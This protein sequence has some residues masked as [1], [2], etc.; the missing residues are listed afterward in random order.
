MTLIHAAILVGAGLAGGFIAGVIGVGGGIIFAPVLFFYF[1]AIDIAPELVTP[2][3]LGSSLLCTFIAAASSA[4]SQ[5]ARGFVVWTT[6]GITGIFSAGTVVLMIRFVT[7]APWYDGEVFQ[8]VFGIL[9]LLVV[10]RMLQEQQESSTTSSGRNSSAR[11]P[12]L[13]GIGTAA[14]IVSPAAGVGGGIVMVPTYH[15]LLGMDLKRAFATSSATIVFISCAGILNYA[16]FGW[17]AATPSTAL[18]YVDLGRGLILA[19]P[20]VLGA[21]WGVHASHYFDTRYLRWG[22]SALGVVVAF[23]LIF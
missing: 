2:L 13:A 11:W 4:Y 17:T 19:L 23:R 22:F 16:M 5:H 8:V 18:G 21:R 20:A 15:H 1:R 12:S 6:A 14:G 9:L 7:T 3:T 10:V